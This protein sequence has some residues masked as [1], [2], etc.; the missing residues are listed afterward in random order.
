MAIYLT[1]M[2]DKNIQGNHCGLFADTKAE[3]AGEDAT[4]AT[5]NAGA[6]LCMPGSTCI[7]PLG[8]VLILNTAGAWSEL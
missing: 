5:A 2:P 6:V 8:E 1:S 4:V 7:T 3:I